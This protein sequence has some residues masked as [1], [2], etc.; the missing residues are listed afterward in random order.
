MKLKRLTPDTI[1]KLIKLIENELTPQ[2]GKRKR[3]RP[4]VYSDSFI[5]LVSFI[6][7]MMNLSFRD[8]VYHIQHTLK[9][10]SPSVSTL[11]YRFSKLDERL[12]EKIF[13]KVLEKPKVNE[14]G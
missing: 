9:M 7:T 14:D 13:E 2:D 11:H 5:L 3:G 12:L 4:K 6:K 8:T 1:Q 10:K